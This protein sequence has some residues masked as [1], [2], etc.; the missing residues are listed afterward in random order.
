MGQLVVA[1]VLANNQRTMLSSGYMMHNCQW[2]KRLPKRLL[3]QQ[4]VL[5]YIT[6]RSRSR[7]S[8]PM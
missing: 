6:I 7:V 5:R 2:R 4:D 3:C 1:F 8:W